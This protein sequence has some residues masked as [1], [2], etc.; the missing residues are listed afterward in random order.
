MVRPRAVV[1]FA[2]LVAQPHTQAAC[3]QRLAPSGCEAVEAAAAV[4]LPVALPGPWRCLLGQLRHR[5]VLLH[6]LLNRRLRQGRVRSVPPG[7]LP[8]PHCGLG[9][10]RTPGSA[11][12]QRAEQAVMVQLLEHIDQHTERQVGCGG[13]GGSRG[14]LA[15]QGAV[16][17]SWLETK[18]GCF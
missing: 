15:L 8:L 11:A 12:L 16:K 5:A 9:T 17:G 13:R 6:L 3:L 14:A 7:V 1:R 10:C 18:V 4:A 2:A